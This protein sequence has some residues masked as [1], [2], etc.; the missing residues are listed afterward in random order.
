[1]PLITKGKYYICPE[2]GSRK[3]YVEVS[4]L[5]KMSPNTERIYDR[6]NDVDNE[7]W[8]AGCGCDNCGWTGG[9]DD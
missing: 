5:A 2:C 9:D 1:M 8:G 4:V 3:V 7:F 6:T